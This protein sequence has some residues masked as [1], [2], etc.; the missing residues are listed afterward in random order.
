MHKKPGENV[1]MDPRAVYNYGRKAFENEKRSLR[2]S[3]KD[4]ERAKEDRRRLRE[5]LRQQGR[6]V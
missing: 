4:E 1:N 5:L 3:D 6:T 2:L